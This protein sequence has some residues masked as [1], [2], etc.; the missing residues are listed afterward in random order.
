MKQDPAAKFLF[1]LERNHSG[2]MLSSAFFQQQKEYLP[3]TVHISC[4]AGGV[5][6]AAEINVGALKSANRA[7]GVLIEHETGNRQ[8]I[9]Q[10]T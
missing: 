4:Q 10:L 5:I 6:A 7:A 9:I 1:Y 8:P 3:R 2:F